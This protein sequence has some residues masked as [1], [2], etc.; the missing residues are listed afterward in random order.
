MIRAVNLPPSKSEYN[1]KLILCKLYGKNLPTIV[2][3]F[4]DDIVLMHNLL[5]HNTNILHCQNAGTV[6]RFLLS[7]FS[8]KGIADLPLVLD[9]DTRMRQRPI[10]DLVDALIS[11]GARISYTDKIGFPPV[12]IIQPVNLNT[13]GTIKFDTSISSQFV[14]SL[15]M[16]APKFQN[17]LVIHYNNI[18]S[19]PYIIMTSQ[20]M[21]SIGLKNTIINDRILISH[22]LCDIHP[23]DIIVEKDWS[24]AAYWYPILYASMYD[25]LLLRNIH[26]DSLQG[27][28]IINDIMTNFGFTT[29][30]TPEG[31]IIN[32]NRNYMNNDSNNSHV[33]KCNL[34]DTPDLAPVVAVTSAITGIPVTIEGLINIKW[35]ESN[36]YKTIVNNMRK[37][38]IN[39]ECISDD[40]ISLS[41][42]NWSNI[43]KSISKQII[44]DSAED[45]RIAMAFLPFCMLNININIDSL[46][47]I[48]KS[49]PHFIQ[50]FSNNFITFAE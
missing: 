15:M 5:S 24:A 48:S 38:N 34:L 36:R 39:I 12:N 10:N 28:E 8:I 43:I 29:T 22:N 31:V 46:T 30:N 44:L 33:Y 7:A 20:M 41:P 25:S 14:S 27:D 49:Y 42:D 50:E 40:I 9:C 37:M 26:T 45:H 35:K 21:N 4:P 19:M 1:R 18:P 47:C 23:E 16:I 17:G 6:I 13:H 3:D 11:L 32:V 2:K